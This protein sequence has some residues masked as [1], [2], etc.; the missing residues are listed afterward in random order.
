MSS[1]SFFFSFSEPSLTAAVH[2]VFYLPVLVSPQRFSRFLFSLLF[3][4]LY[5]YKYFNE[6]S[7][8]YFFFPDVPRVTPFLQYNLLLFLF[9]FCFS[10]LVFLEVGERARSVGEEGSCAKLKTGGT[11]SNARLC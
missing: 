11:A 2:H 1:S 6:G 5:C 3:F 10:C 8:W 9:S 4:S 7:V